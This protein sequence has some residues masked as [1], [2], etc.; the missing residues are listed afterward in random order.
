MGQP[1]ATPRSSWQQAPPANRSNARIAAGFY[2]AKLLD[3]PLYAFA[4]LDTRSPNTFIESSED[5]H[6]PME[7]DRQE[8]MLFGKGSQAPGAKIEE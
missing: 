3:L 8:Q 5:R 4:L 2:L 6:H 7:W 1:S